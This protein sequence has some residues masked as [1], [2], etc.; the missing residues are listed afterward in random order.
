MQL[1]KTLEQLNLRMQAIFPDDQF[2]SIFMGSYGLMFYVESK[3]KIVY[4]K[5]CKTLEG[6]VWEKINGLMFVYKNSIEDFDFTLNAAPGGSLVLAY[7]IS[8]HLK[9]M[10]EHRLTQTLC[11]EG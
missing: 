7:I 11:C 9:Y 1:I 2:E 4:T 3:P 10:E 6:G 8:N 5:I